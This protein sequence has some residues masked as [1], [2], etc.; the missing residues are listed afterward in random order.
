MTSVKFCDRNDLLVK[1]QGVL[2]ASV[3]KFYHP[4]LGKLKSAFVWV[5]YDLALELDYLLIGSELLTNIL[6]LTYCLLY[7]S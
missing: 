1:I 2:E 6:L 4:Q 5:G 3:N 7:N